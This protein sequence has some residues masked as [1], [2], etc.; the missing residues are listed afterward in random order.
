MNTNSLTIVTRHS[1]PTQ[2]CKHTLDHKFG[3]PV[4][5]RHTYGLE[6][7]RSILDRVLPE[8]LAAWQPEV[9]Q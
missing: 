2:P 9:R 1:R 4:T 8:L 7:A 6:H 5:Q 3:R